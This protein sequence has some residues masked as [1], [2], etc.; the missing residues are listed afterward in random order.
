ML[1]VALLAAA[2][3]GIGEWRFNAALSD[4]RSGPAPRESIRVW[5]K[6]GDNVRFRHTTVS[7][8]GKRNVTEFVASYGGGEAKVT[9]SSRYDTVS[10]KA[11]D[12]RTV[13]QT[14]RLKGEVTVRA[15][16]VISADGLRMTITAG[17][18]NPD[19]RKF[20]NTLVYDRIR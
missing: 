4:Y 2:D 1:F 11:V 5:E 3:L 17:G 14:F 20:V 13:E 7:R 10:L 12:E 16:R 19:G 9:G 6:A 15:K 8:D 18:T